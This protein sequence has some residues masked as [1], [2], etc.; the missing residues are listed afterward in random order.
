MK[1]VNT[2][3]HQDSPEDNK[4]ISDLKL[5]MFQDSPVSMLIVNKFGEII[6]CNS[7]LC[8]RLNLSKQ[9]ITNLSLYTLIKGNDDTKETLRNALNK[10]RPILLQE[11]INE[12]NHKIISK[13]VLL[14]IVPLQFN[15]IS[16]FQVLVYDKDEYVN[17]LYLEAIIAKSILQNV[18]KA[19]CRCTE[20][21]EII[22]ANKSFIEMFEFDDFQELSMMT[23]RKLYANSTDF[24][25]LLQQLNDDKEIIEHRFQFLKKNGKE[26]QGKINVFATKQGY[27]DTIIS[28]VTQG[29]TTEELLAAKNIQL[30]KTNEQLDRFL[31]STSHDLRAPLTSILGIINLIRILKL[32][33]E[34]INYINRIE[35]SVDKLDNVIKDMLSFAKNAR[36]R[37][38]SKEIKFEKLV[39][40]IILKFK[41]HQNFNNINFEINI[42]ERF[43][44]FG[45]FERLENVFFHV[46]RNA[47]FFIDKKKESSYIRTNVDMYGDKV[48]IEIID[49]G[50]GISNKYINNIFDMFYR[51]SERSNGSGL[52]LY[53]VKEIMHRLKGEVTVES[54]IGHGTIFHIEIPN[55]TKGRLKSKKIKLYGV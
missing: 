22:F 55:G 24:E 16:L 18:P 17:D 19:I 42:N 5:D 36:R 31:Y 29:T 10:C 48:I 8:E 53:I 23:T 1:T 46:I 26:F 32:N 7:A 3:T 4:N 28:E 13:Q 33:S 21:G 44:F 27:Y 35:T 40:D 9:K 50:I 54:D 20:Y 45:D 41:Y 51:G 2:N 11:T 30:E 34:L 38:E 37:V 25:F 47:I 52:G 43:P 6:L 39:N 49:N 14:N 12:S 15:Q